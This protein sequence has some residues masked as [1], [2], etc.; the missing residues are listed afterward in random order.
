[1]L[2]RLIEKGGAKSASPL[3]SNFQGSALYLNESSLYSLIS[4]NW[5]N[6]LNDG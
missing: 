5:L 3:V 2:E 6:R 1:M 4:L